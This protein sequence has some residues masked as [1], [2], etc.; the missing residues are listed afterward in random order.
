M[1]TLQRPNVHHAGAEGEAEVVRVGKGG[2]VRDLV[3]EGEVEVAAVCQSADVGDGSAALHEEGVARP[4]APHTAHHVLAVREVEQ[5]T[6][7][8]G[9]HVRDARALGQG[10]VAAVC[11]GRHVLDVFA[12]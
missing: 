1:H 3:Q 7:A 5:V 12:A 8:K 6:V 10:E 9:R 11:E 2:D 4:Q